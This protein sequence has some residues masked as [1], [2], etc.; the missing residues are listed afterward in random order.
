MTASWTVEK[1]LPDGRYYWQARAEDEHGAGSEWTATRRLNV[2][3]HLIRILSDVRFECTV[4]ARVSARIKLAARASVTALFH[5]GGGVDLVHEFGRLDA[6]NTTLHTFLSYVLARPDTYW[7][8]WRAKRIGERESAWMRVEL[9][10]LPP[11]G[12]PYCRPL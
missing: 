5:N 11:S 8:E 1:T 6:G 12:V 9:K 7:I 3:K 10:P 4:G 2:A